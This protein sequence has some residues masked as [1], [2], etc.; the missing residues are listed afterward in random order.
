[1]TNNW[2]AMLSYMRYNGARDGTNGLNFDLIIMAGRPQGNF[3]EL[4]DNV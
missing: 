1:M 3:P 2:L 4:K